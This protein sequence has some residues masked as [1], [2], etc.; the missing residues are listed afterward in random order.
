MVCWRHTCL[1]YTTTQSPVVAGT[2][3]MLPLFVGRILYRGVG[4]DAGHRRGVSS[5]QTQE[6][7]L[8]ETLHEE[9]DSRPERVVLH[10]GNWTRVYQISD[11]FI[12]PIAS[13]TM[14]AE[15]SLWT[16]GTLCKFQYFYQGWGKVQFINYSS[17]S[18]ADTVTH[19]VQV[20]YTGLFLD[21][22]LKP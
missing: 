17:T 21:F 1:I 6:A 4:N 8:L 3:D 19:Q 20:Q 22:F 5:P 9:L 13:C 14:E 2:E 10:A 15:E 11:I 18:S 12:S 16:Q 7:F